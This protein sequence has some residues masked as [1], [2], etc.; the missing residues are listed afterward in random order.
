M[1]LGSWHVAGGH[2]LFSILWSGRAGPADDPAQE[3]LGAVHMLYFGFGI[4]HIVHTLAETEHNAACV[5]LYAT[6]SANTTSRLQPASPLGGPSRDLPE[7]NMARGSSKSS[8]EG[9]FRL[10]SHRPTS[11]LA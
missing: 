4:K 11:G 3:R 6:L 2:A 8:R 10:S 1:T 9:F 7:S 5:T